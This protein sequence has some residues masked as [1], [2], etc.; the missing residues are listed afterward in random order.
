MK[1]LILNGLPETNDIDASI[2]N[3]MLDEL[4]KREWENRELVLR[5]EKMA[6]C[7][8]CFGCWVKTPGECVIDDAGRGVAKAIMES[9]LVVYLTHV[10]FGGY[11]SELKKALDRMIPILSPF[12]MKING[13]TH[14]KKRYD[15]YPAMVA[16]GILPE[17]DDESAKLFETLHSRNA[18]NGHAT[19]SA[20]GLVEAD[21]GVDEIAKRVK[22]LLDQAGDA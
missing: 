12:F 10:T 18:I 22:R 9:D 13:E 1:V 14:H 5:D 3:I 4:Q 7:T 17:P 16:L 21:C 15:R 2:R 11:S 20:A 19:A 6:Y 8:G